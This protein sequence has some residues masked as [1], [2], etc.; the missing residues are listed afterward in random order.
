MH[1]LLIIAE[2][3]KFKSYIL[4]KPEEF[5]ERGDIFIFLITV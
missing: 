1:M 5:F 2:K 3:A 4:D